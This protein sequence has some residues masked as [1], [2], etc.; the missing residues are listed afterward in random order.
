MFFRLGKLSAVSVC[1]ELNITGPKDTTKLQQAKEEVYKKGFYEGVLLVGKHAGEAVQAAKTAVREEL[2]Q[3]GFGCI[4]YEPEKTVIARSGDA[5]VV[6]LLPQW[7]L[8]Y[9][10]HQWREEVDIFLNSSSFNAHSSQALHQF[11]FVLSWLK[12][13]ACSRNYGLGTYLPWT[14]DT[15]TPA[16]IESLSDS[17][18]YMAYYTVAHLIQV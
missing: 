2:L 5:C 14:Q 9:G 7:F 10:E 17:T 13:W 12:E 16:L 11:S 3:Q 8:V 18:I 4:Y 1:E 6:G 15:E